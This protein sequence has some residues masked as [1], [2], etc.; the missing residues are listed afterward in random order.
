MPET[1]SDKNPVNAKELRTLAMASA[2]K[3]KLE[4]KNEKEKQERSERTKRKAAH[5][6][7]LPE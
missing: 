7:P 5:K 1:Y 3:E 2:P 4:A 6:K